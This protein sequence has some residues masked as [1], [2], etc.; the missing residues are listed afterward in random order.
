MASAGN[1]PPTTG[2][3]TAQAVCL[4]QIHVPLQIRVGGLQQ[5]QLVMSNVFF[6]LTPHRDTQYP[7]KNGQF[8]IF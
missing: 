6:F 1:S 5:G 7:R 3:F 4:G 8:G 2:C